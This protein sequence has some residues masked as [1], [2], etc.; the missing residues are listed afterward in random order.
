MITT[1]FADPLT[2]ACVGLLLFV[3]AVGCTAKPAKTELKL[4]LVEPKTADVPDA[5]VVQSFAAESQPPQ[6]S[7][8]DAEWP[9]LFGPH[10]TSHTD[11]RINPVWPAEG[12]PVLWQTEIG[13]GYGSPVTSDGRVIFNHRLENNDVV[14]CREARTGEVLWTH[15]DP[16][17]AECDFEYSNGPYSTPL[18]DK[19]SRRVFCVGGQG[20]MTC[21]H[22]DTGE[23]TWSRD[24]NQEYGVEPEIFPTGSSPILDDSEPN[25]LQLIYNLGAG[26]REAG[27]VALNAETGETI[28]EST[29]HGVGYCSPLVA[30]IHGQRFVFVF[31]NEGLVCLHPDTGQK[32]WEFEHYSRAPMSYNAVSPLLYEEKVLVVTGPG[33]GAVCL[34]VQPD[35]SFDVLWKDRR[36]IDCQ[37][38]TL[39]LHEGSV[40]S[41]TSAGQGGAEFR[42]IDFNTGELRWRYHSVLRRGQ[43]LIANNA[44][45]L[46]GERGHLA[47]LVNTPETSQV[48]SFTQ[49]PLMSEPC[50]CAPAIQNGILF[51]KDEE[52]LLA[53]NV[54]LL[55]GPHTSTSPKI[56]PTRDERPARLPS[57]AP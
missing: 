26:D 1:R 49:E 28:W 36:V 3:S 45:I 25:G 50:Y 41:F 5:D 29:T 12:P 37:Y 24:L 32:D 52:R 48:I 14:E 15:Q 4:P 23:V 54:S 27:V 55:D 18:I 53:L 46:L 6:T 9:A 44:I 38:N 20:R 13:T 42:C 2:L 11:E 57:I 17:S 31:T 43:G 51:L 35:R 19:T 47:S 8:A 39:M 33:P 30:S 56:C 21:L 40:Y 34:Q 10:R 22:F 7:P 16:T